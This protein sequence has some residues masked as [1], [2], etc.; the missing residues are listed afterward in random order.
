MNVIKK[1]GHNEIVEITTP[2]H[3]T[4]HGGKSRLCGDFR[5]L[6]N[7]TKPDSYPIPR[8]PHAPDKLE[9]PIWALEKF[10]YYFECAVIE[11]Y[12]DCTALKSLHNMKTT[13]RHM[14]RWQIAIQEYKDKDNTETEGT[15]TPIL[16][17][18][19]SELNNELFSP[20]TKPYAK[21]KQCI[22]MLQLLQQNYRSPELESE[23]EEP[24]LRDYKD[25]KKFLIDELLNH[26]EKHTGSLTVIDR[27]NI[28]LILQEFHNCLSMG[29]IK[30][31]RTKERVAIT[32]WWPQWEQEM[33]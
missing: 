25:K 15:E 10:H 28:S 20:V 11:F 24:W 14:L 7:Y 13:N 19:S 21:H 23:L 31:D 18:S 16:G 32:A 27:D 6:N 29:H 17:I 8:I 4:W 12:T 30:E 22:I 1:I 26:R 33:S 2:V 9:K 5:A 3:I